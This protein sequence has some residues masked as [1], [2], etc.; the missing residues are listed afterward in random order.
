MVHGSDDE[1]SDTDNFPG[2]LLLSTTATGATG[3]LDAWQPVYRSHSGRAL[4]M[5][6]RSEN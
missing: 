1:F 6:S 2:M 3:D 4:Q 5:K